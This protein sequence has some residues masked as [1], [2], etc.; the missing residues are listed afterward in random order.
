M[1][2]CF[3]GINHSIGTLPEL[4]VYRTENPCITYKTVNSSKEV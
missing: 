1:L 2:A 4:N 3:L